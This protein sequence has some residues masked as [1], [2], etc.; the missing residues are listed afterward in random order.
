ME[1]DS[2]S[3]KRLF[4]MKTLISPRMRGVRGVCRSLSS[5]S[6]RIPRLAS[7]WFAPSTLVFMV[8][9]PM[10]P[11]SFTGKSFTYSQVYPVARLTS[12]LMFI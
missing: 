1:N 10:R 7:I 4:A 3:G 12:D 2:R 8:R 5:K 9:R 6:P 11:S